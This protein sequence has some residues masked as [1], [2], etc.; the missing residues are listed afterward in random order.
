MSSKIIMKSSIKKNI[1]SLQRITANPKF[2]QGMDELITL[3]KSRQIENVRTAFKIA[4]K[5]STTGKGS[6]GAGNAG[7]KLLAKYRTKESATGK[8]DRQATK[9]SAKMKLKK[10]HIKGKVVVDKQYYKTN[11]KT[12]EKDIR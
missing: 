11:S 4:D 2:T 12:K 9:Q 10:Y 7:M 1:E 3:Y 5:L 6:I 8:L